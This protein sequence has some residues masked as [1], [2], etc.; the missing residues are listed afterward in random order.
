MGGN[1]I[2]NL[3]YAVDLV[4]VA[5]STEELQDMVSRVEKAAK[6]QCSKDKGDDKDW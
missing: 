5:T 3:R 6:D 2:N 1:I 4:L